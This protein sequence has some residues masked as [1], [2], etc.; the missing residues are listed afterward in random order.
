MQGKPSSDAN[1]GDL[2]GQ[3]V[4]KAWLGAAPDN[5][6]LIGMEVV[7]E[8]VL[9]AASLEQFSEHHASAM[10][11]NSPTATLSSTDMSIDLADISVDMPESSGKLKAQKY[12][13]SE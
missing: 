11:A 1:K 10:A 6:E 2:D 13:K 9:A 8:Q 3:S 7:D 5:D 4:A 12:R